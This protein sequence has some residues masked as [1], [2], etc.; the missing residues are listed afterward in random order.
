[1]TKTESSASL[2]IGEK[3]EQLQPG[4]PR[5]EMLEVA[6]RFKTSWVDLGGKLYGVR[7][8][9]L[10]LQWGFGKFEEYCSQE[11]RIKPQTA[12]KLT[13]S[14]AFL[15]QEGPAVLKRDGIEKPVPDM[16]VIDL[17]RRIRE[18]ERVPEREF[19]RIKELAFDDAPPAQVRRELK[20]SLPEPE[21]TSKSS[22]LKRLLN[23]AHRLADGLAAISGIPHVVVDRAISLVDDLRGLVGS[24][25]E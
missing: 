2:A 5:Y 25:G 17:L 21:P 3:M 7:N 22:E 6:R 18:K 20:H 10:F 24:N 8:K 23:L 12:A 16:Q 14:Y 4:T 19:S 9:R 15:K 11:L 1:M 13:A